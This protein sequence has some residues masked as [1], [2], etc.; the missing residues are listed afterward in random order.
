MRKQ[1]TK[2]S[3]RAKRLIFDGGITYDGRPIAEFALEFNLEPSELHVLLST[4][5]EVVARKRKNMPAEDEVGAKR[6]R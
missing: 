6:G 2:K 1:R 3:V 4:I 5:H